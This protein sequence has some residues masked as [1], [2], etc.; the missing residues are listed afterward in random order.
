MA[1]RDIYF[2]DVCKALADGSQVWI[3]DKEEHLIIDAN[4]TAGVH[5]MGILRSAEA[6]KTNRWAFWKEVP[7]E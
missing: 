3:C 5:L 1:F 2:F 6:D 7:K 4:D